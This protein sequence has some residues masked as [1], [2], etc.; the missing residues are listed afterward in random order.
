[1]SASIENVAKGYLANNQ[2]ISYWVAADY[3]SHPNVADVGA[4]HLNA[5]EQK[6]LQTD[7]DKM[8]GK[9]GAQIT[10]YDN[11]GPGKWA[12][13][14]KQPKDIYVKNEGAALKGSFV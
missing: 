10:V 12:K 6:K 11:I 8:P 9:I 4:G 3:K 1:M 13:A 7:L 14:A 5:G 2:A